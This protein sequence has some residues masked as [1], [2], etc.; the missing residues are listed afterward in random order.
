MNRRNGKLARPFIRRIAPQQ[1]CRVARLA[2]VLLISS[3]LAAGSLACGDTDGDLETDRAMLEDCDLLLDNL[4]DEELSQDE[5]EIVAETYFDC[6]QEEDEDQSDL[7]VPNACV[8]LLDV[9]VSGDLNQQQFEATQYA[10][11][12]CIEQE[13]EKASQGSNDDGGDD[14]GDGNALCTTVES[15]AANYFDVDP[16]DD[17]IIYD[18][19]VDYIDNYTVDEIIEILGEEYALMLYDYVQECAPEGS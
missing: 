7:S 2:L 12:T 1:I 3:F 8:P 18:L 4:D 11:S 13:E 6:Q 17:V 14:G 16:D 15:Y 9:L 19:I 5:Y 10:V